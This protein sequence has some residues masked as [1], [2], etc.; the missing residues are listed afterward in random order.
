MMSAKPF[1]LTLAVIRTVKNVC[2]IW[3]EIVI[4]LNLCDEKVIGLNSKY[5]KLQGC[6]CMG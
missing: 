4:G 3:D 6:N 1:M 5:V 2:L